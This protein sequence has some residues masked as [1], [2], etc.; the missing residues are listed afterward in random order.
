M[1][2]AQGVIVPS[3]EDLNKAVSQLIDGLQ[4]NDQTNVRFRTN[5]VGYFGSIGVATEAVP[6]LMRDLGL[7]AEAQYAAQGCNVSCIF[8]TC[9]LTCWF[10]NIGY[11]AITLEAKATSQ[12]A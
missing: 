1:V 6:E 3:T 5:P 4:K 7:K 10:T 8:T 12:I 9:A 2:N 11:A